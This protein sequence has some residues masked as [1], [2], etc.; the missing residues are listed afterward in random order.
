M[1]NHTYKNAEVENQKGFLK[2]LARFFLGGGVDSK[3]YFQRN[4]KTS[5]NHII[6]IIDRKPITAVVLKRK[7]L[8]DAS[9]EVCMVIDRLVQQL[10]AAGCPTQGDTWMILRW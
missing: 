5:L 6:K 3:V 9:R 4:Y 10:N 7:L 8:K 1:H 2:Q